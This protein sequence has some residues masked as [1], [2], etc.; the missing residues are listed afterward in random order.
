MRSV[1]LL[2]LDLLSAFDPI[3]VAVVLCRAEEA[4]KLV[5]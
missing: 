2:S 1:D 4:T 5:A 3:A